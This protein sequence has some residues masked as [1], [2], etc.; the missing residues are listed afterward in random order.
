MPEI[1]IE[2][3]DHKVITFKLEQRLLTILH[4]NYIDWMHACGGKGRCT[5]C[6]FIVLSG[7]E[8]ITPPSPFEKQCIQKHLL[9]CNQ[10]LACQCAVKGDIKI[11]VPE[12]NKL[13]HMDYSD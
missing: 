12:E 4:G 2:N 3:L 13:P 10:R 8:S 11:K 5:T 1:V 7:M 9:E 6:K